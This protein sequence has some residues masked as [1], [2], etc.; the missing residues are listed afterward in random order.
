MSKG[1]SSAKVLSTLANPDKILP[2]ALIEVAATG[3]RTYQGYKR[4]GE[5]E[6]R[7][8]I[9]EESISAVFWLFG[10]K[11]LNSLGDMLGKKIGIKNLDVDVGRDALRQPSLNIPK[12]ELLKTSIFKF[13]KILGSAVIATAFIG[14]VVPRLN[15]M[16]TNLIRKAHGLEPIPEKRERKKQQK[17]SSLNSQETGLPLAAPAGT[18]ASAICMSDFIEIAKN[19]AKLGKKLPTAF[20]GSGK[21]INGLMAASHNL[22]HNTTW[23][24]MSTDVGTLS[25]RVANSRNS[26]EA[27]EFLFRDSASVYFY[28][29]A[30]PTTI[31]LMNKMTGNTP[32][33]P[34]TLNITKDYLKE[35]VGGN[36]FAPD[37]F[38]NKA[39]TVPANVKDILSKIDF[40][41]EVVSLDEFNNATQYRYGLKAKVMSQMQPKLS[42]KSVLSKMQAADILSE[43][44][45]TNPH[46]LKKAVNAGTYGAALNPKKFVSK[47]TTENIRQSIDLFTE[48]LVKYAK[49]KGVKIDADLIEKFAKR[50]MRLNLGYRAL[51]MIISSVGLAFLIPKIQYAMTEKLTGSKAF[52]GTN[53]YADDEEQTPVKMIQRLFFN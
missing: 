21:F 2:V 35:T 18:L 8:R 37:D 51:G 11:V 27:M 4:G 7:E 12:D 43:G 23:R 15:H 16:V 30:T 13:S 28:M 19:N 6:A 31:W 25:G 45:N 33:H 42:G 47:K 53:S 39:R 49:G 50:T 34:D 9:C 46:F 40:K 26:Y 36:K 5:E 41:N 29:F 24:L 14:I 38:A 10:A 48:N 32:I 17:N 1:L 22:E 44:W 52:P 20:M 3:G